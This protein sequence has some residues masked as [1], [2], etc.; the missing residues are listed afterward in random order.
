MIKGS[1]WI[2]FSVKDP[3]ACLELAGADLRNVNCSIYFKKV[4]EVFTT[5][6]TILLGAPMLMNKEEVEKFLNA[7]LMKIEK[8]ETF[9]GQ[10]QL[11]FKVSKEYAPGIPW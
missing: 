10:W 4:Q 6:R 9:N 1:A 3:K 5:S 11:T 2:N 8:G 7:E